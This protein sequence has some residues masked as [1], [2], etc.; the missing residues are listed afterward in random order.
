[1][2]RIAAVK[3]INT[4]PFFHAIDN[5][6]LNDAVQVQSLHPAQCADAFK[7]GE[8]DVALVPVG[9]L[10]EMPAHQII[11]DYCIGSYGPVDT[12]AL[13]SSVPVQEIECIVLDDHSRTSN[14]LIR[15]LCEEY[16]NIQPEFVQTSKAASNKIARLL[17]G[18]KVKRYETAFPLKY[19][20]GQAWTNFSGLPMVFA[21]WIASPTISSTFISQLNHAF[22]L[23]L[24]MRDKIPLNTISNSEYWRSYLMNTIRYDLDSQA[25]EGMTRFLEL[26]KLLI[27]E[28]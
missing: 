15:I 25:S 10:A 2:T 18:D 20:L 14:I 17:I 19:D 27:H 23:S 12:V 21:V 7:A 3:Y 26:D 8:A 5:H 9:A 28:V 1:M 16:W 11:T 24:E 13:L 22:A 4:L 6:L